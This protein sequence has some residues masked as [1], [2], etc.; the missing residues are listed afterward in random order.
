[1]KRFKPLE[2]PQPALTNVPSARH[3]AR[4][5]EETAATTIA[6]ARPRSDASFVARRGFAYST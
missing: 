4:G 5:A 2:R 1:M 6:W 3:P